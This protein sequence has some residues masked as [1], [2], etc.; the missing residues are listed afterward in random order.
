MTSA[1][2]VIIPE[3]CTLQNP[4]LQDCGQKRGSLFFSNES[5]TW[6]TK[7]LANAGLYTLNT[8][9]EAYLGLTGSGLY[10]FD[11]ISLATIDAD[12]PVLRDQIVVGIATNS[13]FLG[14]LPLSPVSFNFTSL[15][16]PIPSLLS[17][18][19][20]A[21]HI[22]SLSWSYTAGAHYQSPPIFGSLVLGGFD[23]SRFDPGKMASDI[24]FGSDF[25][26]DLL[27]ELSSITYSTIGSVPLLASSMF[28]FIDSLATELWLPISVCQAFEDAFKLTWDKSL[29]LYL[30]NDTKHA[31]LV[32]EN[33]VF[34]F[35]LGGNSAT[36][37][38]ADIVLP[39]AAFD[40][41]I[42]PPLIN[43]T[44]RYFPLKRAQNESSYTL[45][46]VFLQEAYVIADYER[47][48][49]SIAQARFPAT[50]VA[51]DIRNIDP[52][53]H[54]SPVHKDGTHHTES[55]DSSHLSNGALAGIVVGSVVGALAVAV[56]VWLLW[57]RRTASKRLIVAGQKG[58]E[59]V[60]AQEADDG[61]AV[62]HQL[63]EAGEIKAELQARE[64]RL[65]SQELAAEPRMAE[66]GN[67]TGV[68]AEL[69]ASR[70]P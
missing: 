39:Y 24:P 44:T 46:R 57:R 63:D 33:P 54:H 31:E 67:E 12:L 68:L 65:D 59:M 22:P 30:I 55:H 29:E 61:V 49:F 4:G 53:E 41:T 60:K 9:E 20:N 1:L 27:V 52:I 6:S 70:A 15:D 47:Q 66:L 37:A 48:N 3:G 10:G 50:S 40:L 16:H 58:E 2:Q 43:A 34:A 51:Q 64:S 42:S 36:G 21:T 7:G 62:M 5:T 28:V 69:D 8:F 32:A 14:T 13:F 45:G 35:T 38:T 25:S 17:N 18:L 56:S 23:A 26:R 19:R 11:T